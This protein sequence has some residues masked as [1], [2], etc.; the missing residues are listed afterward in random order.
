MAAKTIQK[1]NTDLIKRAVAEFKKI[2][3]VKAVFLFGSYARGEQK[4]ISDID[5]CVVAEKNISESIKADIAGNSSKKVEISLFWDLPPS[6]RYS[7][8]KEARMLFMRDEEF[9]HDATVRTMSEYLDFRHIIDRN[10][11]RVF[12]DEQGKDNGDNQ[13]Y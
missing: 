3:Q 11:A 9:F 6:V 12:G 10:I 8:I 4:P 5:I 1:A 13:G 7:A 2:K